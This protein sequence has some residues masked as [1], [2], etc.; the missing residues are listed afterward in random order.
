MSRLAL[1]GGKPL[2]EKPFPRWPVFGEE[3]E[4]A[5]IEVLRSGKWGALDGERVKRFQERFAAFQEAKFGVCVVNGTVALEVAL[6][7]AGR[8]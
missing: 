7:A 8:E 5:L 4:R 6:R 2:R 3:E 1:L